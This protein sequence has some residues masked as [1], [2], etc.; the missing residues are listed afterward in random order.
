MTV[1]LVLVHVAATVFDAMG[2]SWITVLIPGQVASTGW[3]EAET[4]RR[5]FAL[6][7]R[8]RNYGEAT[9]KRRHSPGTPLSW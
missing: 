7:L 2:N 3:P 6:L 4:V 5:K 8:R 9:A 1:G